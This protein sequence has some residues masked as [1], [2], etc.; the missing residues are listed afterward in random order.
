MKKMDAFLDERLN[1]YDKW[2]SEKKIA[3]SSKV[4]PI[5][6]SLSTQRW[7]LPTEQVEE[8]LRKARSIALTPCECRMHYQRCDNPIDVCL[9]L[10]EIGDAY[11]KKGLARHVSPEEAQ[12]IVRVANEKG[13]VHLSLYMPDHQLYALCSCC[14]C[15]CHDLQIVRLMDRD[16]L[17]VQSDYVAVTDDEVC[18]QCGVCIDRCVFDARTWQDDIVA[19]DP[20]ACY[21]CGLCVTTCPSEAITMK[22]KNETAR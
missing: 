13:L 4:I 19:Y 1:R 11:V 15:C 22:R 20:G 18:T 12:N 10:N 14:S 16:D 5:Q 8:I 21:G 9:L 7:V 6:E 17:M 2:L 3:F